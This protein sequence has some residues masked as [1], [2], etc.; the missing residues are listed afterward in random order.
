MLGG[1]YGAAA[2]GIGSM[3]ADLIPGYASFA[4]GTLIIKA[5]MPFVAYVAYKSLAGITVLWHVFCLRSLRKLLWCSDTSYTKQPFSATGIGALGAIP[6]NLIQ[7]VGGIVIS[8]VVMEL[9][10]NNRAIARLMND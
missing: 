9:V 7:A 5:L 4:P 2:G 8:V 3:L 1:A 6:G 10:K